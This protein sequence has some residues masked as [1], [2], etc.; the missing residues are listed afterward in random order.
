MGIWVQLYFHFYVQ[1]VVTFCAIN[2]KTTVCNLLFI[3]FFKY[4]EQM[5]VETS[6]CTERKGG[7]QLL[8]ISD[9]YAVP[10]SLEND[11]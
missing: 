6:C 2:G 8:N 5:G 9:I 3:S 1:I 7:P 4:P 11:E 10:K